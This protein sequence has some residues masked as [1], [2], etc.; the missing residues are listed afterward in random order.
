MQWYEDLIQPLGAFGLALLLCCL[1]ERILLYF[2]HDPK[3]ALMAALP[4]A[5]ASTYFFPAIF[6]IASSSGTILNLRPDRIW[7]TTVKAGASY[8][9]AVLLWTIG[10]SLYLV[11]LGMMLFAATPL[12][13]QAASQRPSWM[14]SWMTDARV[15]LVVLAPAI[16]FMHYFCWTMGLIYRDGHVRF[17][18]VF[19][20][21]KRRR[22]DLRPTP[23]SAPRKRRL[24][25][26][27]PAPPPAADWPQIHD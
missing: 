2:I 17:P 13:W 10:G 3:V 15:G 27:P 18:W 19:Q 6:M 9:I 24:K 4:F 26:V 16:Y 20:F 11:C 12:W 14:M 23:A 5:L 7:G 1:P 21:H 8:A 22:D 25:A